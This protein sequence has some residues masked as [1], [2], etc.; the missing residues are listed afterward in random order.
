MRR[1]SLIRVRLPQHP[2]SAT[3]EPGRAASRPVGRRANAP[4]ALWLPPGPRPAFRPPVSAP[5]SFVFVCAGRSVRASASRPA[6]PPRRRRRAGGARASASAGRSWAG[7]AKAPQ[8]P[9]PAP[10]RRPDLVTPVARPGTPSL[11]CLQPHPPTPPAPSSPA[12]PRPAP[13]RPAPPRPTQPNPIQPTLPHQPT[14]PAAAPRRCR[15]AA[16]ARQHAGHVQVTSKS[17]TSQSRPSESCP[18]HIQVT[19]VK[20]TSVVRVPTESPLE[21]ERSPQRGATHTSEATLLLPLLLPLLSSLL[22]LARS[23]FLSLSLSLLVPRKLCVKR[24][25]SDS[26]SHSPLP[27]ALVPQGTSECEGKGAGGRGAGVVQKLRETESWGK[28]GHGIAA[29]Q[30]KGGTGGRGTHV[31]W[32][33]WIGLAVRGADR[34]EGMPCGKIG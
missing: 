27:T 34:L 31:R 14:H 6:G 1:Y 8:P 17:L 5:S 29:E 21:T 3:C 24:N 19:H 11:H 13:P 25:V 4:R 26:D 22:S 20:V 18:S 30:R 23:L 7:R 12:P 15:P 32:V 16:D 2:G 10:P 33:G 9:E 28:R